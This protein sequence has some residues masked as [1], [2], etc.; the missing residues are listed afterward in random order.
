MVSLLIGLV[1]FLS[2][3]STPPASPPPVE[4][5][6]ETHELTKSD[7]DAWLDGKLPDALTNGAIPGAMVVVVKDGEILTNRVF[8]H[9]KLGTDNNTPVAVNPDTLFR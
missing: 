1:A 5:P 7:V 6:T 8:G 2:A 3:C 4:P 9:A